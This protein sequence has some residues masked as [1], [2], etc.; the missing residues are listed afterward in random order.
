MPGSLDADVAII[1]SGPAG[2]HAA[3]PLVEA[4]VR[5]VVI[6]GGETEPALLGAAPEAGFEEIRR[7]DPEQHRWFLG[8]DL[9]GIPVDSPARGL[10]WLVRGNRSYVTRGTRRL[11]PLRAPRLR[12]LESLARGGLGAAW[13][14]VC[15]YFTDREIEAAGLPLRETRRNY[16]IIT[17]RIGIS[18]P[19]TSPAV[20]EAPRPDHHTEALLAAFAER[21]AGFETLG[22]ELVRSHLALLTAPLGGRAACRYTDMHHYADP[23]GSVYR[24]QYTLEELRRWKHFR[25]ESGWIVERVQERE[26]SVEVHARR[27]RGG[28]LGEGHAF[29]ARRAIIAAGA[30]GTA[31]I[32]LRSFRL[33]GIKLPFLT[34]RQQLI[35]CL[36]PRMLGRSGAAERI[37]LCQLQLN[38][39]E[40]AETRRLRICAQIYSYRSFLLC[41]LLSAL[42]VAAPEA[43]EMLAL[44][45]PSV[46]IADVRFPALRHPG[47]S[48]WLA[49]G[50]TESEATLRIAMEAERPAPGESGAAMRLRR[51]LRTLGLL[52]LRKMRPPLGSTTHYGGTVPFAEPTR[53]DPL[54]SAPNGKLL[55]G[56]HIYVADASLLRC[57][58]ASATTLTIMANANRIGGHV[59]EELRG[60]GSSVPAEDSPVCA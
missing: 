55:Q 5:V 51:A 12:V 16:D 22:F 7:S 56:R 26:D 47:G 10:S 53:Q 46:V 14:G 8:E 34:K 24:P 36:H 58:P 28:A 13:G 30:V 33:A 19:R 41:R 57:L 60:A 15:A 54:A 20:Q 18:G 21:A 27:N 23:G 50:A 32:L 40:A 2:V 35:A 39:R 37:G 29:R 3:Y 59:L 42:P 48:L 49:D 11:L 17:R 9:S 45:T 52:P 4:G 44:L 6:D 1:G 38:E 31:R 43:L 25:H